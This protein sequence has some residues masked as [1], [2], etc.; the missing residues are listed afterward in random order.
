MLAALPERKT[1]DVS[2][3]QWP[4]LPSRWDTLEV[5]RQH[6]TTQLPREKKSNIKPDKFGKTKSCIRWVVGNLH[7]QITKRRRTTKEKDPEGAA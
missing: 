4:D 7:V 1:C 3:L 2:A 6:V 5:N